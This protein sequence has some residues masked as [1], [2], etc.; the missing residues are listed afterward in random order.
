VEAMTGRTATTAPAPSAARTGYTE[1]LV[2]EVS[3]IS[4]RELTERVIERARHAV[5]DWLGVSIAGAQEPS[6]RAIQRPR[7]APPRPR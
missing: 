1:H 5:L 4:S 7:G 3:K 2:S 6:A